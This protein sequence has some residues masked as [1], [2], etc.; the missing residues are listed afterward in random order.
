M[1]T[2][3]SLKTLR[4]S[5]S[6]CSALTD[7]KAADAGNALQA[8]ANKLKSAQVLE[9]EGFNTLI[10]VARDIKSKKR[11]KEWPLEVDDGQPV[12][13]KLGQTP[14]G[15]KVR[16][17]IVFANIKVNQRLESRPPFDCFDLA[18][19]LEN[20]TQEPLS[21]WH[22]DLANS[23]GDSVQSGPL[24]HLQFGGRNR[25]HDRAQDHPIKEP[26]WCHPPMELAL[27]SEMLVAN[28]FESAWLDLREDQAWCTNIN[29][30]QKLC[31]E[32]Y[33]NRLQ[34]C[35]ATPSGSTILR[36]VWASNW[37]DE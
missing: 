32:N 11:K 13:F 3:A 21:R 29:L 14:D 24:F 6:R 4:S 25:G 19:V 36:D 9:P 2:P 26:R 22:I 30:F 16:P 23:S 27:I 20:E 28:F 35:L 5:I 10:R 33:L 1:L 34:Q 8:I 17:K 37:R 31:Y 12:R 15:K 18:I 7:I